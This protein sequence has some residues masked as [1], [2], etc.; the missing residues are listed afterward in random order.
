MLEGSYK[1]AIDYF[2]KILE[3]HDS[4]IE[5]F[6]GM[7]KAEHNLG[8]GTKAIRY[9]KRTVEIDPL[10]AEGYF[11][12]GFGLLQ[13]DDT[14]KAI[15]A[16]KLSVSL[17]NTIAMAY[18]YLCEGLNREKRSSAAKSLIEDK[19]CEIYP[20]INGILIETYRDTMENMSRN[21]DGKRIIDKLCNILLKRFNKKK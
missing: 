3:K 12:L 6:V 2:Q 16:L 9:Y 15:R 4:D 7:G 17:D 13:Y 20:R 8:N 5:A 18:Y 1:E 19:I 14:R 10:F 21:I 11:Y